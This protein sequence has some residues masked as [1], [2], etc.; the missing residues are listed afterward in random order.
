[1]IALLSDAHGQ[2]STGCLSVPYKLGWEAMYTL[3]YTGNKLI[4]DAE[5]ALRARLY[6][7][8]EHAHATQSQ[9]MP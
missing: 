9:N 6:A 7:G 8:N 5:E 3:V 1:M 4:P 2:S